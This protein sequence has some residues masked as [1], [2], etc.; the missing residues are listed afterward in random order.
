MLDANID[1]GKISDALRRITGKRVMAKDIQ[2]LKNQLTRGEQGLVNTMIWISNKEPD[3]YFVFDC[4]KDGVFDFVS[5]Q[6]K[7][8]HHTY[9]RY[10]EML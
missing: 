5:Y 6:S 7:Q 9:S 1:I 4:D 10:P 8:M 3:N 2:N